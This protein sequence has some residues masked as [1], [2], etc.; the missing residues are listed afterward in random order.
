METEKSPA[1]TK[2]PDAYNLG[3]ALTIIESLLL[4][5]D[6]NVAR[7]YAKKFLEEMSG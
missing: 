1:A 3:R 6:D 5:P 4:W 7:D 2:Y